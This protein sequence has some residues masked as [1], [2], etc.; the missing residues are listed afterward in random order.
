MR[1]TA[2]MESEPLAIASPRKLTIP[3]A[4][5]SRKLLDFA[6]EV[7]DAIDGGALVLPTLPDVAVRVNALLESD[8]CDAAQIA[9]VIALDP[10]IAARV[11]VAANSA[12]S[13]SRA[14]VDTLPA[15]VTRLGMRFTRAM[16]NRIAL[17]Q[18]FSAHSRMLH[19]VATDI[20]LESVRVGALCDA[21]TRYRSSTVG[22]D[23]ALLAGLLH[24]V[25]SLPVIRLADESPGRFDNEPGIGD[26][27]RL[28]QPEIGYY[29]L[30]EWGFAKSVS[31]V[32]MATKNPMRSHGGATD[33]LDVV[34]VARRLLRLPFLNEV[35]DGKA[36][37][38]FD[39]LRLDGGST[40]ADLPEVEAAFEVSLQ[41]I[42]G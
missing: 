3:V 4:G 35:P 27:V 22:A 18:M 34:L 38:A 17:E 13:Q 14:P 23:E 5:H 32:A 12:Y 28:L 7:R 41:R 26:V 9:Q 25:G 16:V 24:L 33:V 8:S 15:A 42:F 36:L 1:N 29:L 11:I 40:L 39:R 10:G 30:E 20:W 6:R 21:L 19:K 2:F 31:D 37:P